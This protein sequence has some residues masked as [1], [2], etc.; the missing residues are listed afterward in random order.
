[1]FVVLKWIQ[2][3]QFGMKLKNSA[4]TFDDLSGPKPKENNMVQG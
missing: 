2:D 4:L 1:M 3:C